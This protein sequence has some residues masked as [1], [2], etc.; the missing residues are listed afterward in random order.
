MVS[1]IGSLREHIVGLG[2]TIM[3]GFG[4]VRRVYMVV[5]MLLL[6]LRMKEVSL[7]SLRM[8]RTS[9]TNKRILK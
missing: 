4:T 1:N 3:Y 8:T 9:R 7:M 2:K 6:T 5:G